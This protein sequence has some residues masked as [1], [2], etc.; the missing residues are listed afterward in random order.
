[1]PKHFLSFLL[2]LV[3]A[4]CL[5]TKAV[6]PESFTLDTENASQ[7]NC[8][9]NTPES[10]SLFFFASI[11]RGDA[12]WKQTIDSHPQIFQMVKE[13]IEK[14]YQL[15]HWK[16]IKIIG[17]ESASEGHV[18]VKVRLELEYQGETKTGTDEISL[19]YTDGKWKITDIPL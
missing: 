1:M 6:H 15:F 12:A 4:G 10:V 5:N 7:V 2:P 3:L 8:Y 16:S 9:D 19:R 18:W 14:N 11:I 13:K 17:Q